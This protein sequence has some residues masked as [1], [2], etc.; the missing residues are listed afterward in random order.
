MI[1][2]L[3]LDEKSFQKGHHYASVLSEPM[4]GKVLEVVEHRT[5]EACQTLLDRALS[6]EERKQVKTLS[7][8]MWEAFL[9]V[10]KEKLPNAE[11]VH[12]RFHLIKY[13]NEAIDKVRRREVKDHAQV[14]GLALCDVEK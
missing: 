14:E 12:D 5:L 7:I 3:S 6:E 4:S 2:H 10:A 8:D 1:E 9:S 11:I 13:L